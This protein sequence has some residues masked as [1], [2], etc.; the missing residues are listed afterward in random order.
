MRL[1]SAASKRQA[2]NH[3]IYLAAKGAVVP[4]ERGGVNTAAEALANGAEKLRIAGRLI[5]LTAAESDVR[6]ELVAALRAKIDAGTYRVSAADVA[7]SLMGS[8]RQ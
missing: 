3:S 1:T 8:L 2:V 5:S 6:F 7:E 4:C